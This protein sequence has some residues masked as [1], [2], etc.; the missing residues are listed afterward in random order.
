MF[1]LQGE[2]STAQIIFRASRMPAPLYQW[3]SVWVVA[4]LQ[5][6]RKKACPRVGIPINIFLI[7]RS[8]RVQKEVVWRVKG[9][10]PP[11][12][13]HFSCCIA[14]GSRQG[15]GRMVTE[16]SSD[17]DLLGCFASL[18]VQSLAESVCR[19]LVH[20]VGLHLVLEPC[21]WTVVTQR[22][23]PLRSLSQFLGRIFF[24][25]SKQAGDMKFLCLLISN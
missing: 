17:C 25:S 3:L 20:S 6:P 13:P 7:E 10:L 2:G 9:M 23:H 5:A 4:V 15:F 24:S 21:P 22:S 8:I 11:S 12:Y 16:V 1:E 19:N 14:G 18:G